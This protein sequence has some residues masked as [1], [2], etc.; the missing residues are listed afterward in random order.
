MESTY[1]KLRKA[2][3]DKKYPDG[4]PLEFGCDVARDILGEIDALCDGKT[5]EEYLETI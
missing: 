2:I 5:L 3:Y 1:E 4:I